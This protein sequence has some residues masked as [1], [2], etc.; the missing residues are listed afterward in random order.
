MSLFGISAKQLL[1][2]IKSVGGFESG[3]DA[4]TVR[5]NV[6]PLA[7]A[8]IHIFGSSNNTLSTNNANMIIQG[9]GGNGLFF[10]TIQSSPYSSYIQSGFV[11][12]IDI[13]NYDFVINPLGGKVGIGVIVPSKPLH[14]VTSGDSGALIDGDSNTS[15]YIDSGAGSAQYVRFSQG[16]TESFWLTSNTSTGLQFRPSA[17]QASVIMR[18]NNK[19]DFYGGLSASSLPSTSIGLS[20]GDIWNDNG[21]VKI[22]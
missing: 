11:H 13:A 1:D 4:D 3:L 8:K 21:T 10:G 7:G 19:V 6:V 5:G 14:V 17:G 22:K 15:L 9:G 12:N 20:A 16:G 2:K 18:Q